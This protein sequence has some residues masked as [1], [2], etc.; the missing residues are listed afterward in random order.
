MAAVSGKYGSVLHEVSPGEY[1]RGLR[2]LARHI[3]RVRGRTLKLR[4]RYSIPIAQR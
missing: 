2:D 1:E 4:L 3:E